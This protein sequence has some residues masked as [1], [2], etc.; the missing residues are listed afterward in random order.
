MVVFDE[1]ATTSLMDARERIDA[2]RFPAFAAVAADATWYRDATTVAGRTTEAVPALVTGRRPREGEL[3]TAA[4]HPQSLFTLLGRSHRLHVVEPITDVCP[5]DLCTEARPGIGS[6]LRALAA[7]LRVVSAHLLLPDDLR[8]GLPPIDSDWQGFAEG[9]VPDATEADRAALRNQ[10]GRRLKADDP[11]ADFARIR[12]AAGATGSRPPLLFLHTNLPHAP[13]W[14]LPDGRRHTEDPALPGLVAGRV[15]GAAVARRPGLPAPSRPDAVRRPPARRPA[16]AAA[17]DRAVRAGARRRHRRPRRELP[18][19]RPAPGAD[20]DQPPGRRGRAA[21]HQAAGAA[22]RAR[23]GRRRAHIDVLPTIAR[24]LGLRLP[25]RVDGVPAGERDSDPGTRIE[26]PDSFG[27]G[28]TGTFG[29]ILEQRVERLRYERSLL[30]PAGDDPYA[31]GPRPQLIG[32]RPGT[33]PRGSGR[34]RLDDPAAFA[35]V[36]PDSATLPAFVTGTVTGLA[37]G[38]ELAV[39]VNGRIEATTRV[40]GSGDGPAV[41]RAGGAGVAARGR[42]PDRRARDRARRAAGARRRRADAFT[43][44]YGFSQPFLRCGRRLAP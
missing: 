29:A 7:D 20:A 10:V 9:G 34:V 18:R 42:E 32:R 1:L 40:D 24:E 37:A 3:P 44:L 28:T 16:R 15:G 25:G 36:R 14:Y 30:E 11:R 39:T 4:H 43:K 23:R 21:V 41:R 6:R 33:P 31:I 19:R 38:T 17:V 22:R 12:R 5:R 27:L 26:V 8:D 13:W 35:D 2:Q